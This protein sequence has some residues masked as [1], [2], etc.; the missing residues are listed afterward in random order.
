MLYHGFQ[1]LEA[2]VAHIGGGQF[3]VS[4][5]GRLELVA[6]KVLMRDQIAPAVRRFFR[7]AVVCE[8]VVGEKIAAVTVETVRAV[9]FPRRIVFRNEEEISPCFSSSVNCAAPRSAR[10]NFELAEIRV[11]RYCSIASPTRSDVI[12]GLP[13]ARANRARINWIAPQF[14]DG[15]RQSL[16]HFPPVLNRGQRLIAQARAASVPR[17]RAVPRQIVKRRGIARSPICR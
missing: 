8:A 4:K 13:K 15:L 9:L 3:H 7:E 12:P 1:R 11:R 10:S 14:R 5:G 16:T 2:S 6:V 17:K